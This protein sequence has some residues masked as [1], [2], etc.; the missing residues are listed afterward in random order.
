MR[1]SL[2][3]VVDI[4][5]EDL[6]A[7]QWIDDDEDWPT[8]FGVPLFDELETAQWLVLMAQVGK[9]LFD[10]RVPWQACAG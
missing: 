1:A 6:D 10:P 4:L 5:E 8:E 3:S 2:A 9:A 7:A